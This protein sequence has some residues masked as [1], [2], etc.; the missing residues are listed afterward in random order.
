VLGDVALTQFMVHIYID[1]SEA[2][3]DSGD[4]GATP[5]SE[6]D[7]ATTETGATG[8]KATIR[9]SRITHT[10]VNEGGRWNLLGGMSCDR[11]TEI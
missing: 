11:E 2:V 6:S 8:A 10:W 9:S 7:G 1:D 4:T 5:D 3:V